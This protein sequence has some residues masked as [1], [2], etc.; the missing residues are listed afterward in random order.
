MRRQDIPIAVDYTVDAKYVFGR[1]IRSPYSR[2]IRKGRTAMQ[3]GPFIGYS[4]SPV[5]VRYLRAIST[6]LPEGDCLLAISSFVS[7]LG[8]RSLKPV[9]PGSPQIWVRK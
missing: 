9:L 8:A 6:S 1:R 2:P 4:S 5:S 7:G 3:H